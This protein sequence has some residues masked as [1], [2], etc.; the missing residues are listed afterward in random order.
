MVSQWFTFWSLLGKQ[1]EGSLIISIQGRLNGSLPHSPSPVPG[2]SFREGGQEEVHCSTGRPAAAPGNV[3]AF[4]SQDEV[5]GQAAPGTCVVHSHG[6]QPQE[7]PTICIPVG[8]GPRT[9]SNFCRSRKIK[10]GIQTLLVLVSQQQLWSYLTYF[11]FLP[12]QFFHFHRCSKT[13]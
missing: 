7:L 8:P 6:S 4:T 12:T 11:S 10:L 3:P 1:N 5:M 2:T 9:T 13:I